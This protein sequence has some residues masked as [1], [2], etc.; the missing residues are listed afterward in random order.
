MKMNASHF[1]FKYS[2]QP[3]AD[4]YT[5]F[6]HTPVPPRML[7]QPPGDPADV[8]HVRAGVLD[9]A[10]EEE[11]REGVRVLLELKIR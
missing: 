2:T 5:V 6:L 1:P 11:R 10:S 8:H 7:S 9:E 4:G 3:P